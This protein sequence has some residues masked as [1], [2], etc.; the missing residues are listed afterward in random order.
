M[1]AIMALNFAH[2]GQ[3]LGRARTQEV[4]IEM[5]DGVGSA[6]HLAAVAES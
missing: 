5:K 6:N 4:D 1:L 3:L 2:P